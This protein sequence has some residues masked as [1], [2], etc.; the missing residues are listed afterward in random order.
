M[1]VYGGRS[2]EN[3]Q[4]V[5]DICGSGHVLGMFL[6]YQTQLYGLLQMGLDG[7]HNRAKSHETGHIWGPV[8]KVMLIYE[9]SLVIRVQSDVGIWR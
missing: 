3:D 4:N 6:S 9:G 1:S 8:C 2:G 5:D 7:C